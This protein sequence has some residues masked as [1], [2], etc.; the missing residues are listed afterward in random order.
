VLK[1]EHKHTAQVAAYL[2]L[3]LMHTSF[4]YIPLSVQF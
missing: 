2:L 1:D 3:L 4:I